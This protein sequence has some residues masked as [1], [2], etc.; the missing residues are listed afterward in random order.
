MTKLSTTI[1]TA[2]CC[3]LIATMA[4]CSG[5]PTEKNSLRLPATKKIVSKKQPTNALWGNDVKNAEVIMQREETTYNS[6]SGFSLYT[7]KNPDGSTTKAVCTSAPPYNHYYSLYSPNGNLRLLASAYSEMGDIDG[8]LVDYDSKGRVS[9]LSRIEP[10]G[11]KGFETLYSKTLD[12]AYDVLKEWITRPNVATASYPIQRDSEGNITSV[13]TT[14]IRSGYKA[15]VYLKEWGPFW[16]SDIDG[17]IIGIF[18]LQKYMGDMSKSHVDYLYE[19]NSLIA[20]LAYW[21]TTFIKAR[22]YNR[23]GIMVKQYD[24]RDINVENQAFAD[25]YVDPLWYTKNND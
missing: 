24:D 5:K 21:K 4:A 19:G 25:S 13:G 15:K 23:H 3:M 18:T 1:T 11:D 8:I 2:I 7:H 10:L 9:K 12:K 6:T 14:E 22:T 17:G 20:E 16:T